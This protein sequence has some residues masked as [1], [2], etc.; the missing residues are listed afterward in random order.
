[1]RFTTWQT[2]VRPTDLQLAADPVPFGCLLL[3]CFLLWLLGHLLLLWLAD[4]V[5]RLRR[6][7]NGKILLY[8][9]ESSFATKQQSYILVSI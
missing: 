7:S 1:M 9:A 8:I 5:A 6:R 2:G 4:D 3:L